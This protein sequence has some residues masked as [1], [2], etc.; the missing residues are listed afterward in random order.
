MFE[1]S[2]LKVGPKVYMFLKAIAIASPSS[3]PLTVRFAGFAKKSPL[4]SI[5]PSSFF[6][7]LC[8]SIV[9]TWNISPAPSQSEAVII[10]V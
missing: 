9:V 2:A 6:G 1:F 5:V 4:K 7:M 10:G 3:C 8:R